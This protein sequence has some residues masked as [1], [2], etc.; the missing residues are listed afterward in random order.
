MT[1]APRGILS[2]TSASVGRSTTKRRPVV[3]ATVDPSARPI[4][5]SWATMPEWVW[6]D[7]PGC[8]VTR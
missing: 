5:S 4:T 7:A 6:N 3:A 1:C 2:T 8:S